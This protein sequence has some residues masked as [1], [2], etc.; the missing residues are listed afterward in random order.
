MHNAP[1]IIALIGLSGTGK[2]T[3]ARSLAE[4]LRWNHKDT[5]ELIKALMGCPVAQIFADYGEG[6]FR[7]LENEALG[8][9]MLYAAYRPSVL[10]TGGGIVLRE[11]NRRL[12][13]KYAHVVWLDA[14]TSV[15]INRLHAHN[16]ERPLLAHND[17]VLRL[18][19]LREQRAPLYKQLAHQT[20]DTTNL[21]P[22]T[23]AARICASYMRQ[24]GI[25]T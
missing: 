13:Q 12:L 19:A 10:A 17:P 25:R 3:V 11:D 9:A 8:A 20:I 14:P 24:L 2:S 18:E 23:I 7:T 6:Y 15:L 1:I 16:E 5:D 21:A 4:L 22:Y